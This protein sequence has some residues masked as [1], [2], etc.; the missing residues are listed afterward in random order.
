MVIIIFI[1]IHGICLSSNLLDCTV[2]KTS[3]L[4]DAI[5]LGSGYDLFVGD[6]GKSV[7]FANDHHKCFL[8][9]CWFLNAAASNGTIVL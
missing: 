7:T 3:L 4:M 5:V 6:D 1:I 9:F 8:G 2:I